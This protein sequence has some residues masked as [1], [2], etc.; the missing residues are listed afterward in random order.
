MLMLML[1]ITWCCRESFH[2]GISWCKGSAARSCGSCLSSHSWHIK[3]LQAL[4]PKHIVDLWSLQCLYKLIYE[5]WF[6]QID[7]N[8]CTNWFVN[9]P[10]ESVGHPDFC[11]ISHCQVFNPIW[12]KKKNINLIL[13]GSTSAYI[14]PFFH[15][16]I[17]SGEHIM[18]GLISYW[19]IWTFGADPSASVWSLQ[20]SPL[21]ISESYW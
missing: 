18:R 16:F 5:H 3:Y 12:Q 17:F 21:T 13:L 6:V 19:L 14:F 8:M 9:S 1:I 4:A 11:S 7:C 15:E 10:E 20:T 2:Q